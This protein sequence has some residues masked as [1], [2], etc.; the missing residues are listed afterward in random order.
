MLRLFILSTIILFASFNSYSQIKRWSLDE[1][2]KYAKENNVDVKSKRLEIEISKTNLS[3]SK[4]AYAPIIS[5]NNS[6]NISQGRVLDPTTYEFIEN[7]TVGG[8]NTSVSASMNLFNGLRN[9]NTIKR[10]KMNLNSA[11]LGVEK[12]EN[13]LM[14]NVTAYFLEVLLAEESINNY[15]Q[16][17]LSLTTQ[18]DNIVKKV[19]VGKVTTADL[20]QVESQLANEKTSLLTVKNQLYI[21]KLNICQLL[22]LDEYMSFETISI[23]SVL[24]APMELSYNVNVILQSAE[25][26]PELESARLAVD[27]KKRDLS[28]TR[29][30]YYPSIS[31]SASYGSSY[32]S[33]RQKSFQNPDGTFK[34]EAYLFAEQ[35]R[36]NLNGYLSLGISIPIFNRLSTR[37]SVQRNRIAISQAEYSLKSMEKQVSKEVN[38]AYIDMNIAWEKYNSTDSYLASSSEAVRQIERK[39]NVGAA[40]IVDYNTAMNNYIDASS[41]H[42]QAKYEYIFKTRIIKFYME[43]K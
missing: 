24:L 38:Q 20:L 16:V 1:C 40:T 5:V 25:S 30:Q 8:N 42:Y 29:S 34:Y 23:D 26:L 2:I 39:Y 32:S 10:E 31:L 9:L 43:Y 27:I 33:V 12:A 6:Y 35:Y 18:R 14:L 4:W 11:I 13:D 7:Q 3:E 41:K 28:I 21:A 15:E 22:D 36:D 17:V 19:K 37:K